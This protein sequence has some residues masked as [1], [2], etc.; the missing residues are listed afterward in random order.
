MNIYIYNTYS[1]TQI[2][3]NNINENNNFDCNIYH[4]YGL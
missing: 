4:I 1:H 3:R 2:K